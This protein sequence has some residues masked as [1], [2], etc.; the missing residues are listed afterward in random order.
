MTNINVKQ[1]DTSSDILFITLPW[2]DN[3]LPPCAAGV[4]KGIVESHGFSM[5]LYDSNIDLQYDI[6]GN[7]LDLYNKLVNYFITSTSDF[8]HQNLIDRFYIHVIEKIKRQN[9]RFLA[10]SVFSVFTHRATYDILTRLRPQVNVPIVLGG[11]G[12]TTRP[13][14]SILNFLIHSH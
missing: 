9:T 10:F 2:W 8:Q 11:R 4:L 12:L 6:C 3:V 13:N 5:K 14:L 7:D 1:N